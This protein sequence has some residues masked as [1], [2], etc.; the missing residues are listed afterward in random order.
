[1]M[2]V[3]AQIIGF[4]GVGL[5]LLSYQLKKRQQ[6]VWVSF[7]SNVFY[8][9][10]YL[11]LG[12]FSG[13]IMD[14]LATVAS[15]FAARKNAPHLKKYTKQLAFLSVLMIAVIGIAIAMIRKDFIELLP[16]VGGIFQTLGLWCDDEQLIRKLGLCGAPFWL[17][18][19]FISQAYGATLGSV[20]AIISII[21]SLVRYR[22]K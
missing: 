14:T 10:Q 20:L 11:L 22:K 3:V 16:I 5:F 6:I 15:F 17:V 21:V 12:A 1:M 2:I 13:A 8:V 9:L 7:F 18:Y 4:A 19:N